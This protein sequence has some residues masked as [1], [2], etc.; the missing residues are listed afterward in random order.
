MRGYKTKKNV[1]SIIVFLLTIGFVSGMGIKRVEA[2]S[3]KTVMLSELVESGEPY[4]N[5]EDDLIIIEIDMDYNRGG[6]SDVKNVE[7]IANNIK[8][9]GSKEAT[10]IKLSIDANNVEVV[11]GK[12][13]SLSVTSD[14]VISGYIKA[15]LYVNKDLYINEGAKV[16]PCIIDVEGDIYV[17]K[18]SNVDI[19]AGDSKVSGVIYSEGILKAKNL[20]AN[21]III[22]DGSMSGPSICGDIYVKGG[23]I[24]GLTLLKGNLT[25]ESGT[26]HAKL[27][28]DLYMSDG[29]AECYISNPQAKVVI[30]G[31]D[32]KSLSESYGSGGYSL[33]DELSVSGGTVKNLVPNKL[34]VSG[35]E[36]SFGGVTVPEI[37]LSGGTI[38]ANGVTTKSITVSGGSLQCSSIVGGHGYHG[39]PAEL[40]SVSGGEILSDGVIITNSLQITKGIIQSKSTI[41]APTVEIKGGTVDCKYFLD[42]DFDIEDSENNTFSLSGGEVKLSRGIND[43]SNV[44]LNGGKIIWKDTSS[45]N[46]LYDID[47][48]TIA[49]SNIECDYINRIGCFKMSSGSCK[50]MC[51]ADDVFTKYCEVDSMTIEG[52]TLNSIKSRIFSKS[53]IKISGGNIFAKKGIE[54]DKDIK[55]D[56]GYVETQSNIGSNNGI[57][58]IADGMY[59][60]EGELIWEKASIHPDDL[61]GRIIISNKPNEKSDDDKKES[62]GKDSGGK[63][64]SEKESTPKYSNEWVNGKWYDADGKQTYAGTLQWKSNA[65]GWWVEDTSGWY[66]TDQWQ[67]IDGIW[68][69]FK[70]DGYMASNEYYKGYWFNSNG[71]W[72]NRYMLRWKSNST[73]WW[74]EDVSGWW[75][76]SSWLKIDGY[77]YYF[78]VSGYMVT[79]QYVDGWW[80]SADGVCY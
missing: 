13:K 20:S 72:D 3:T 78:D 79:S 43:Y 58:S 29:S 30:E 12:L 9:M 35:G 65:T 47:N 45:K 32:F 40:I 75:P 44:N 22:N 69:Y 61:T 63:E 7:V 56:G 10:D 76:S 16:N 4:T 18:K 64:S 50:I 77:W 73:G 19:S 67:K 80:I 27:N 2:E 8:I 25:I 57:I 41:T 39:L 6:T 46:G 21:K 62:D 37:N 1:I 54:A 5:Y 55:I 68:Y 49:G 34:D 23:K 38:Q 59:I 71:S 60:N 53:D 74:V 24:E 66:P 33:I 14:L 70:P 51:G 26:V 31:G 11:S 48:L 17:N 52:G 28:G 42:H 36:V 15:K